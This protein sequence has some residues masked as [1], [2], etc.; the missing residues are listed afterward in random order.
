MGDSAQP[1]ATPAQYPR[2]EKIK[3]VSMMLYAPLNP[4]Y[5]PSGYA[6][7]F[8]SQPGTQVYDPSNGAEVGMPLRSPAGFPLFYAIG[9]DDAGKKIVV[10]TPSVYYGD[11][12][13][14]SDAEVMVFIQRTTV[15]P[16]QEAANKAEWERVG[17]LLKE[18]YQKENDK[19]SQVP[20]GETP[21]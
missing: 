11:Q 18:N 14:N 5:I 1:L 10:G 15:T 9:L 7:I 8:G 3:G 16:E 12:G 2:V 4:L 21:L 13:F 20:A 6:T 17:K 19:P